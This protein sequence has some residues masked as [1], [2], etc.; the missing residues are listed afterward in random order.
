MDLACVGDKQGVIS[1]AEILC[2]FGF[3]NIGFT[4]LFDAVAVFVL[5]ISE[6]A[7]IVDVNEGCTRYVVNA[8]TNPTQ[9]E[10]P[11]VLNLIDVVNKIV[12]D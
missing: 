11:D 4:I 8:E 2:D 6:E 10:T 3:I 12:V 5:K 7:V 1:V 9:T